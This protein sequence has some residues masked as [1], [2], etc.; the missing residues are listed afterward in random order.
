[1]VYFASK[2]GD[3]SV[4]EL[5]YPTNH[6]VNYAVYHKDIKNSVGSASNMMKHIAQCYSRLQISYVYFVFGLCPD[7]KR[8]WLA[9][10]VYD[11]N[12]NLVL[13]NSFPMFLNDPL[14]NQLSVYLEGSYH[15]KCH[16]IPS[17]RSLWILSSYQTL[18]NSQQPDK[19]GGK[20]L[21][22]FLI[23]TV[24]ANVLATWSAKASADTVVTNFG[25]CLQT[26]PIFEE[27]NKYN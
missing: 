14:W 23:C 2:V 7:F 24:P 9:I 27:L 8:F 21:L 13:V 15:S 22:L 10:E 17:C 19:A 16:E 6:R 11:N 25:F 5:S 20:Q 12:C 1:M 3:S 18:P 26:E 4:S